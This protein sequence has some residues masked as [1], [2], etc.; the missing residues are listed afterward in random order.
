MLPQGRK[1]FL[2][3]IGQEDLRMTRVLPVISGLL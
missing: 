2:H 1:D 3:V